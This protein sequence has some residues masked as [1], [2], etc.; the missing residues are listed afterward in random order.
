MLILASHTSMSGSGMAAVS[1]GY[2][3]RNVLGVEWVLPTGEILRLGSPGF[4]SGWFSG[5]GPGPSLRG[6]MRGMFGACGGL[7]VFTKCAAKLYP[8]PGPSALRV[9]GVSPDYEA[10]IPEGFA[11]HTLHFPGWKEYA[12]ASYKICDAGIAS[13]L[14]R[15]GGFLWEGAWATT[16]NNEFWINIRQALSIYQD[17]TLASSLLLI[18]HEN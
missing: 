2:S 6:V 7:G 13:H 18:L 9:K 16:S 8:W 3:A 12:G 15:S 14:Y 1:M 4:E 5:D 10:E 17:I 11:Y